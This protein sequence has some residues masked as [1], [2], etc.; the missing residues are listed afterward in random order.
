[1][2]AP[3]AQPTNYAKGVAAE[4]QAE[5]YLKA[6]GYEILRSRYKTKYG[7]IDLI[8]RANDLICFVE[9]KVRAKKVD[10]LEAVTPRT[11][12]RIQNA[13]LFFISENP[14]LNDYAMRFDVITISGDG[15]ISH[16]DNAWE[17]CP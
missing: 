7:E 10:A 1:M 13:A 17:A 9:V 12:K 8:A 11:R 6:Q 16:L 3:K 4:N 14:E 15:S 5:D 2:S